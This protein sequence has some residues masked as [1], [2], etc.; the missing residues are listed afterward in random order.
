MSRIG[1]EEAI[2]NVRALDHLAAFDPR[3]VGTPPLRLDMPGSDID[4][5]CHAP[6][7]AVFTATLSHAFGHFADFT[8]APSPKVDAIIARFSA[9]GWPFEIFGQSVPVAQQ[10]GWRHYRIEHRLLEL[11]GSAAHAA[12]MAFRRQGM[13]TEPAFAAWLDLEGDPYAALLDLE[14]LDDAELSMRLPSRHPGQP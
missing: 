13:K 9:H 1:Y 5:I 11:A 12:V 7:T 14:T 2:H 10:H 6:D 4:I 8:V 3:V